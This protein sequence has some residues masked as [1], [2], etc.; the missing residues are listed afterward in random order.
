MRIRFVKDLRL[1]LTLFVAYISH[2][3]KTSYEK[4]QKSK[5]S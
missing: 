4:W 3:D 5:E 1:G 2:P